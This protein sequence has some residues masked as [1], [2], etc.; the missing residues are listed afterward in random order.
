ME[1]N[2]INSPI[3]LT[4]GILVSNRIQYI[5]R[6]MEGI[7]PLLENVP[8]E[9]IVIDTKGEEGDG[10]IAIVREYT[11]K[12]YPFVWCNDFSKARNVVFE[13]AK[14]EWF[15][16]ID[17]DE[18]LEGAQE[19]I[20]FFNGDACEQYRSGS[21]NIRNYDGDDNFTEGTAV[22]LF[23]RGNN[24]RFVG[25]V[26]E[27]IEEIGFPV[28]EFTCTI[29]HYGYAFK[30]IEEAK[31]HQERNIN[32]LRE[33]IEKKGYTPHLCAQMTQELIYLETSTEEGFQFAKKVLE[34]FKEDKEL[35][36]PSIQ[37]VMY[38][39]VLYYIRKQEVE[40]AVH[41][42][43]LLQENYPLLEITK[44]VLFGLHAE[45]ALGQKNIKEMLQ[46]SLNYIKYWDWMQE[47]AREADVQ[48][49]LS[50][51]QYCKETYY[52]RMLHIGAAAANELECFSMAQKFWKRFPWKKKDFDA[53]QYQQDMKITV[54]GYRRV[55]LLQKQYSDIVQQLD[56]LEQADS[57]RKLL[58]KNGQ[59]I[60]VKKYIEAMK[61]L[62]YV[63]YT[64][65][66][67]ILHESSQGVLILKESLSEES[68][69]DITEIKRV[70]LM[71]CEELLSKNK[72]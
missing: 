11:N 24:T 54:Q 65:L 53:S 9:L 56:I 57:E 31:K 15:L 25:A 8:S 39:T 27:H 20:E 23:R 26:H 33:E 13:H 44:L 32:I 4:I 37:Y 14:G 58:E 3:K 21:C 55:Q 34:I 62:R 61:Q 36:N 63:L 43:E 18:V 38:A 67:E 1:E 7:R 68:N 70:V 19:I 41:Q 35:L 40:S 29:H 51:A 12:V 28:K 72:E 64:N 71:E 30:N 50:F 10:S 66:H 52:H 45:L 17:D 48:K 5:R 49:V 69:C 59:G 16:V 22:R 2:L 47:H 6:V 46:Q 42:I 60:V